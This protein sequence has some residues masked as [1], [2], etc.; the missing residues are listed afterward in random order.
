MGDR[1]E[2]RYRFPTADD[3]VV[4]TTVFYIV[5][6]IGKVTGG[7]GS[8]DIWHGIRLSDFEP[9][10]NPGPRGSPNTGPHGSSHPIGVGRSVMRLG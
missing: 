5:E 6:Q 10:V 2:M 9:N 3:R 4:L 7:I 8:S 1:F